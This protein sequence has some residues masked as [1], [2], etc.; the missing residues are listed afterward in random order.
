MTDQG[1]YCQIARRHQSGSQPFF[2]QDL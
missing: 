1:R 2:S